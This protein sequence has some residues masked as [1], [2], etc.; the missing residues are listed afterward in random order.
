MPSGSGFAVDTAT[1]DVG[2][3]GDETGVAPHDPVACGP[4]RHER[5]RSVVVGAGLVVLLALGAVVAMAVAGDGRAGAALTRHT[6]P[7]SLMFLALAA[8]L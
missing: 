6:G 5:L 4:I 2:D 8:R 3:I 1:S 7:F